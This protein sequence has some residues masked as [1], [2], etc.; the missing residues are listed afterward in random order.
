MSGVKDKIELTAFIFRYT[1]RWVL[2]VSIPSAFTTLRPV[3][4]SLMEAEK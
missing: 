3:S 2:K 1:A 4:S